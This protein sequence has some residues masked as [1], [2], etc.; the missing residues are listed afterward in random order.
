MKTLFS[1]H[2]A[3]LQ[4][5]VQTLLENAFLEG[6]WVYSGKAK[7]LF[8]DDQNAPFKIN[9]YFNYFFP[10]PQ[11]E[12][13]WLFLD[14]KNKPKIYFY[15]PEDYWISTAEVP[16][17]AF[18]AR[19][20][21]WVIFK[22][23]DE[24]AKF[25]QNPTACG[26]IGE[27]IELATHL[28]FSQ[29]NSQKVLNILNFERTIKSEFEI[30]SIYQA[31]FSALAG[32]N[33]AKNAFFAGKSEFEINADY[34]IATKQSELNVPYGNIMAINQH[35][36][37]LH[38]TALDFDTTTPRHSFLIDAGTTV[39]GYASDITRTYAFDSTSEFAELIAKMEHFK[40]KII[41]DLAVG[42]NYLHYHTQMQ[43]M[44]S[45]LLAE[46]QFIH[47]S[48]E[49]IFEE[50]VSRSFF[51]HGL[52]H[53]LGIQVHDVAG[54]QQ[55]ARGSR[56]A[57]PE[58]YPSLRCTRDLAE[59]MVLTIEPGFYFIDML[60]KPWKTH[61]LSSAFNWQKIE[62]FKRF[63][64]IRTED[65]VVIRPNGAENLT[66]KAQSLL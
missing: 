53:F 8:L 55:T 6:L 37:V 57:P 60:L 28:G 39:N 31:Q 51:P 22:Q 32:H 3:R 63:G 34:L 54:F 5:V 46:H 64:G 2:I 9:P 47:L 42:V 52:G 29:I 4:K 41:D 10:Y 11:A 14:G 36:A 58:V 7:T 49:Q 17:N 35:G 61:S 19:E 45:Q 13:C 59:N 65:N 16:N 20:F 26:F 21:D 40:L 48:A 62:D 50:G 1:Q 38:Y 18:F 56:K 27:D 66:A 15:A 12:N 24:I 44:I 43:Q 23:D 30:E 33:T 25:I